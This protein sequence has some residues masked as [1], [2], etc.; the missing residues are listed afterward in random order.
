[1]NHR[2]STLSDPAAP[3]AGRTG[4]AAFALLSLIAAWLFGNFDNPGKLLRASWHQQTTF[5]AIDFYQD[6]SAGRDFLLGES[7]YQPQR[8]NFARHRAHLGFEPT[9][10]PILDVNAHP[11][12][13]V[14]LTLPLATVDYVTAFR[15]WSGLGL[16]FLF[17][18]VALLLRQLRP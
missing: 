16:L 3:A 18:S 1:M 8:E 15:I 6:W 10:V 17:A 7:I 4:V 14:L 12:T 13:L 11:P 2:P 5:P 9:A